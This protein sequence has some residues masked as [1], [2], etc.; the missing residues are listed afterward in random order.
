VS[1]L[2]NPSACVN[3]LERINTEL[4]KIWQPW[5]KATKDAVVLKADLELARARAAEEHADKLS[6]ISSVSERTQKIDLL[7]EQDDMLVSRLAVAKAQVEAFDRIFKVYDVTR[8]N[9]QSAIKL[10]ERLG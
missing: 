9:V 6:N 1:L 3:E 8:S 4:A 5:A 7:I 2:D 10:H